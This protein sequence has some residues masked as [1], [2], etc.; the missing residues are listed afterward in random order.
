MDIEFRNVIPKPLANIQFSKRSVW[1][2]EFVLTTNSQII[3]NATS[4]KGKSTFVSFLMG[5]R[6]DYSGQILFDGED[7]QSYSI[8]DWVELRKLKISTVFQTLELFPNLTVLENIL[9]KNELTDFLSISDIE[10]ML[11]TLGISSLKGKLCK[12][13]SLGQKQ[14][15]AIIRALAQP[16]T[17][18]IL[19]E[20]FSHLDVENKANALGLIKTNCDKQEA[21]FILTTLGEAYQLPN[22]REIWL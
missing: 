2:S 8:D 12:T 14:R 20:P 18:L 22:P 13:L 15:V 4:G 21:G 19:D 17:C 11:V 1:D 7:I 16:F 3:L 6:K 10:E 9:I 5:A